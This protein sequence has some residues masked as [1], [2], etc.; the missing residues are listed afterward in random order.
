MKPNPNKPLSSWKRYLRLSGLLIAIVSIALIAFGVIYADVPGGRSAPVGVAVPNPGTQQQELANITFPAPY[1][2]F[3]FIVTCAACHGGTIDQQAGHFGN[4]AGTAMASA[5]RDPVFRA[6]QQI[7]NQNVLDL[8]GQD[9]AGNVCIRCHSPNAWY[10]GRTDPNLAGKAD[11]SNAIHSI[12]LS[13]DDEGVMCEFCHRV[14]GGVTQ[15]RADLDPNDPAWNMMA[16][17]SDWPHQG[18]PY[19]DG[20]NAGMPYGDATLQ[21]LDGMNYGGKYGGTSAVYFNDVPLDGTTYT[22]Q[23]Y[24]IFPPGWRDSLGNDVSGQPVFAPDGSVPVHFEAP[25]GPPQNADGTY[26]YQDQ[27]FSPEHTTYESTFI[28]TSEFCGECHDLTVP[29]LNHGMPEQRTYTEWKFSE[30]GDGDGNMD[31]RCQDCHMP[32]L[33]H[34]YADGVPVSLNADPVISG[35]FPYAK[36]RNPDGGTSF[37]KFGG[38]NRDLPEMMKLLY[39]EVDMEVLGAPTGNDVRIFPGML[40][41]RDTM[42]DRAKRNNEI[43]MNGAVDL[44]VI[45][46]PVESATIPGQY[47][48]TVRVINNSGHRVPS[49]YPDGRR[50]F[51]NMTVEDANGNPV[52]VSGYYDEA[53]ATLYDEA[54]GQVED[55][56]LTN[57]IDATVNNQVMIYEKRTGLC[58]DTAGTCQMSVNLLNDKIL[59]DNRIPPLGFT[60]ADYQQAGTKFWSYDAATLMPFED[61]GRYPD[62]QNWDE[63]TYI[64]NAPT[65]QTLN[66]RAAMYWQTHTREFMEYL[67]INNTSTYRP[68][69]GP[70]IL[71]PN[72]PLTPNYLSDHI[73][74]FDTMTSMDG[75]PLRDNWGGVT[76]A[77]WL[78][79]GKG[80]PYMVGADDTTMTTEPLAPGWMTAVSLD[81]FSVQLD[82]E[83]VA[84]ADGY[85][86]WIRYGMDDTTASWDSLAVVQDGTTFVNDAMNVGKTYAFK[87]QAYN[88]KGFSPDSLLASITTP[89][90]LPAPPIGTQVVSTGPDFV[91]L[92]W[93]D[94]AELEI[95]FIVQ[96]QDVPVQGNFYEVARVLSQTAGGAFGGNNWTD[97]T[98]QTGMTYNYRIAAYNDVGNS[99]WDI[100]V[101]ASTGGIPNWPAAGANLVASAPSGQ[102]VNLTWTPA[103]GSPQGYRIERNTTGPNGPWTT[104]FV[105]PDSAAT[106]YSDLTATPNTTYW[107]RVFA[108]TFGGDSPASNVAQVTTPGVAPAAPSNLTAAV[109]NLQVTLNWTDNAANEEGFTIERATGVG[110]DVVWAQV[111]TVG[112]DAVSWV[113]TAVQEKTTYSYRV[114]AFADGGATVSAYSNIVEAVVAGE[115]PQAPEQLRTVRVQRTSITLSWLDKSTNEAGFYVER[116]TDGINFTRVATL[117]MDVSVYRDRGLTRNTRYWYR[118]QAFNAIGVT[119]FSETITATTK[120]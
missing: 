61:L 39:P 3:E 46:G 47:E 79:T 83:P 33:K 78:V 18:N 28:Q 65:G 119:A 84:D 62:G 10:S 114:Q 99:T 97:T 110:P 50:L 106:S 58:D 20:P 93:L 86:V 5:M 81:P 60:Y 21:I 25:I 16:G 36:D 113:D 77:A 7:V 68:E 72:Y 49:G 23:T 31:A 98:V 70:D 22:G 88:G 80:A 32:T 102:I 24:G 11:A 8:T 26:N 91:Q 105:V 94:Q 64:F 40:S 45:S 76:Y 29:V 38:S 101:T 14:I 116:S 118:V 4:W 52:Y 89:V 120:R 66:A 57:V 109:N 51:I 19:P 111:A 115:I 85:L 104:T 35:W 54:G 75:E 2:T 9:G 100:P 34:E 107:Y 27:A 43:M 96:R 48:V 17:L 112:V 90:N 30:F 42:Y 63:V 92:A 1:N 67:R 41:S 82:W 44:E 87:V 71:D 53:T 59:F 73:P 117:T 55:R 69:G 37:H 74:D 15:Q 6:N 103:T 95:G 108:Y 12:V 13:T 56:A